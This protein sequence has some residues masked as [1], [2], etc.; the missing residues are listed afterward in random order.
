[1]VTR[2]S[3]DDFEQP[4]LPVNTVP[5]QSSLHTESLNQELRESSPSTVDGEEIDCK[6]NLLKLGIDIEAERRRYVAKSNEGRIFIA[7]VQVGLLF[8]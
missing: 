8:N 6:D 2:R 1:M 7:H 4:G 3:E 5:T